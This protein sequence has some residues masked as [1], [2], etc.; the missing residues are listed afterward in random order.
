MGETRA[1][2]VFE[3]VVLPVLMVAGVLALV[4]AARNALARSPRFVVDPAAVEV[5]ARPAWLSD[6]SAQAVAAELAVVLGGPASLLGREELAGW[7]A[8]L[9]S[10]SAWVA[11]VEAVESR[12]PFQADVRV[13]LRRPVLA[14]PGGW[15]V[16]AEGHVVAGDPA[17]VEPAPL[18]CRRE[19]PDAG[20][21]E[22]AAAAGD[23]LPLRAELDALGL[24]IAEVELGGEGLV[25]FVT[26]SGV[27]IEWG[28]S[29]RASAFSQ[30]DLPPAGRLA[31]LRDVLT[32][33]PGLRGVA[34]VKLWYDR[35]QVTPGP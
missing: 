9:Q 16:T 17:G 10:G 29:S 30:F 23:I 21:L 2:T 13:V 20:A 24:E 25:A 28:R 6:A 7:A 3:R 4:L 34:E 18:F 12:F 15:L 11:A 27:R 26:A 31:N 5:M 19:T 33:H 1:Q 8:Q 35:P 32:R 22:C 14:L